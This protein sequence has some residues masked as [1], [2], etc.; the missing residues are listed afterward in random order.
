MKRLFF[1][2]LAIVAKDIRIELRSRDILYTILF[3]ALLIVV[4]FAFAFFDDKLAPEL[5]APGIMWVTLTFAGTLG[6]Q[7]TFDRE[8]DSSCLIGVVLVPGGIPALYLGKFLVNLL[9]MLLLTLLSIPLVSW[10]MGIPLLKIM[11]PLFVVIMLGSVGFSA[12]GTLISATL[13][14]VKMRDVL[15]PIVLYPLMIPLLALGVVAS[16]EIIFGG[17]LSA[18]GGLWRLMIA[19]DIVFIGVSFFLF[20]MVVGTAG[21]QRS[22]DD[23]EQEGKFKKSRVDVF[24]Y[25]PILLAV[26][27]LVLATAISLI[28]FHAPEEATLGIV[29]KIFYFHVPSAMHAYVGFFIC[30]VGSLIYLFKPGSTW[31]IWAR[32][33]AEIG[34]FFCVMVLGSGPLWARQS[35][36]TYWVWD[37]RL[38]TTLLLFLIY[39]SYV[40]L[41]SFGSDREHNRRIAAVIGVL[42]F[43]NVPIIHFSV[44]KW[45][46]LHPTVLTSKGG[47]I[48]PDMRPAFI[49]SIIA[50]SLLFA[51]VFW[52]RLRIGMYKHHLDSL[53]L[54]CFHQHENYIIVT[55]ADLTEDTK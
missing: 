51:A 8:S 31:D 32:S 37:P 55:E 20:Q 52:L 7:R 14:N 6:I 1:Q 26:L 15:L 21:T 53:H 12:I 17:D 50:F 44:Q 11:V 2:T 25:Y 22:P 16:K 27:T 24:K 4:I 34:L 28:F 33:G 36:G 48:H 54:R 30:L 43:V 19:I 49:F 10:F 39:F 23:A 40:L 42:G 5:V 41:L 3:L 13:L 47:G 18:A 46:G 35:W 9:F 38:T 29:Q 45:R